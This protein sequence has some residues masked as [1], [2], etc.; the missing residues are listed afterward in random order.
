MYIR[1]VVQ[2]VYIYKDFMKKSK[3]SIILTNKLSNL[4]MLPLKNYQILKNNK[5]YKKIIK[6]I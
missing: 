5:N 6:F 3:E 2:C 1:H 4:I